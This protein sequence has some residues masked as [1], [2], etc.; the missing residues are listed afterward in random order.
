MWEG[1]RAE[2]GPYVAKLYP[3]RAWAMVDS[4]GRVKIKFT[5]SGATSEELYPK[6]AGPDLTAGQEI[7]LLPYGDN[8]FLVLGAIQQGAYAGGGGGGTTIAVQEIGVPIGTTG[9]ISF[10]HSGFDVYTLSGGRIGISL[11]DSVFQEIARDALGTALVAGA[12]MTITPNDA[13]ILLHLRLPG[14]VVH[15]G[16]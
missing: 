1:I 13:G 7:V 9:T 2:L 16:R 11:V 15:R 14:A 3:R 4:A 5:Q 6:L 12:N 10:E 8:S